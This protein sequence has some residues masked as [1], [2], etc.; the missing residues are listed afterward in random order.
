MNAFSIFVDSVHIDEL[1]KINPRHLEKRHKEEIV[2]WF[3]RKVS[4]L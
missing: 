2:S 4:H 3:T 1:K